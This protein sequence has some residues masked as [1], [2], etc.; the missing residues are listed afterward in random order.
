MQMAV[1]WRRM[2]GRLISVGE[3]GGGYRQ[4]GINGEN[5][6]IINGINI[7]IEMAWRR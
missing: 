5:K 1:K 3:N 2:S 7:G 6:L 4:P